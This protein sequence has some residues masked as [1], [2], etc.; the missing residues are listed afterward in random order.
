M[1]QAKGMNKEEVHKYFELL[2]KVI[3][4]NEL[5]DR[6]LTIFN[7]GETGFKLNNLSGKVVV[8]NAVKMSM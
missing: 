5:L 6:P 2:T 7:I 3:T 1:S 8:V 4:E